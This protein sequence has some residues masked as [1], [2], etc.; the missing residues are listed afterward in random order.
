MSEIQELSPSTPLNLEKVNS[1]GI[2]KGHS[3]INESA[4]TYNEAQQLRV[5]VID[6]LREKRPLSIFT[7]STSNGDNFIHNW[8]FSAGLRILCEQESIDPT[9]IDLVVIPYAINT[10]NPKWETAFELEK[11]ANVVFDTRLTTPGGFYKS[12]LNAVATALN[13]QLREDAELYIPQPLKLERTPFQEFD[14]SFVRSKGEKINKDANA[15]IVTIVQAGSSDG[16]RLSDDQVISMVRSVKTVKPDTHVQIISD[17]AFRVDPDDRDTSVF[18]GIADTVIANKDINDICSHFYASDHI[19]ATDSFWGWVSSG[20][21][22]MKKDGKLQPG[23]VTIL[24]TLAMPETWRVPG[25][26]IVESPVIDNFR[27]LKVETITAKMYYDVK[28]G[29]GIHQDDVNLLQE[30]VTAILQAA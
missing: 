4:P 6:A 27:R 20:V 22:A 12:K 3:K 30:R 28:G 10:I 23:D 25:A 29:K 8:S 17:K 21:M 11:R 14:E 2:A 18:T 16:K 13:I 9:N 19:V 15:E 1:W 7:Q 5:D 24:Y 26:E